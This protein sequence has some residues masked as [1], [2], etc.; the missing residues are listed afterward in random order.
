MERT[1]QGRLGSR[2]TR[3]RRLLKAPGEYRDDF[4]DLINEAA[5]AGRITDA[6]LYDL[7]ELDFIVG[8]KDYRNHPDAYAIEA[9]ITVDQDDV[10]RAAARAEIVARATG[11]KVTPAV[12]GVHIS[13][14]I[15]ALAEQ[16]G[17]EFIEIADN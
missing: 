13:P 12:A 14:A 17:V 8:A 11:G 1:I 4:D 16:R 10:S 5:D 6:E 7:Q 2:L 9:S 3:R 15:A